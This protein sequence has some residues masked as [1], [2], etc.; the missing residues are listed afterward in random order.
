MKMHA[1][2]DVLLHA[3]LILYLDEGEWTASLSDRFIPGERTPIT[4]CITELFSLT[5]GLKAAKRKMCQYSESN[6][7]SLVV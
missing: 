1:A 4:F 5:I 3:F 2:V 7:D 6:S